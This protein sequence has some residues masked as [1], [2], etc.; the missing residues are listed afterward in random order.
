MAWV[1]PSILLLADAVS[2]L[3]GVPLTRAAAIT[4]NC[5]G[6]NAISPHCPSNEV[7]YTRDAFYVGGRG[8]EI[9]SGMITAD[10]LY[11]EKLT[12]VGGPRHPHPLVFFHG[13]AVS[14]VTW[15]NT[16]DNRMGIASY[17]I[18]QGY[19][20][21]LMDHTG[22]GRSSQEDTSE[23]VLWNTTTAESVQSGFTDPQAAATYPQAILHTQ[24]PGTGQIGD[25]YF[26]AFQKGVIPFTSNWT[27][28]EYSMRASGCDLLALVG[29]AYLVSHSSGAQYP[30]VISNDCPEYVAGSINLEP[31]VQPFWNYGTTLNSGSDFRLWGLAN[32]PLDYDPPASNSSE[33]AKV[34]V[35]NDTLALRRCYLQAE[36]VRQ[37]PSIASVP[38]LAVT[39]EAS[40]HITYDHCVVDYLAQAGG[41]P[42]WIRLGDVGIHG[43]GHF[44]FLEKNSHDIALVLEQ[45]IIK[46]DSNSGAT[47]KKDTRSLRK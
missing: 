30:I 24:W 8:I 5:T 6:L 13:G 7:A 34:W 46:Q 47:S 2:A 3:A 40:V 39:G 19:Q 42:E 22:V 33:L 28:G 35:G 31:S 4:G 15:L 32:T 45:W 25:P 16:P 12:P 17:F 23:Y 27:L 43:N 11:V 21:Y 37:L 44:G 29:P 10:Q 41:S 38:F 20:V 36:P 14:G 18:Q 1:L 9:S 26:E